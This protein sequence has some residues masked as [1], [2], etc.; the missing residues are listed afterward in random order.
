MRRFRRGAL[1][2]SLLAALSGCASGHASAAHPSPTPA[3]YH[4]VEPTPPP[5]RPE[6]VLTDLNGKAFDFQAETKGRPTFVYFGYTHCPDACPTA[7]ADL[8][9]ALRKV[10]P[11]LRSLVKIIFVTTDPQRDTAP[12]M[13]QWLGQFDAPIIGLTGTPAQLALAQ[14]AS[15]V[16]PAAPDGV[17]PT[18]AGHPD[19]H[20]HQPGTAPHKHFGPLGYAVSHSAVIF[21]YDAADRLPVVYPGGVTPSDIAADIPLLAHP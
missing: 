8:A 4:G 7:M 10:S 19:E 17:T 18:I 12:V 16:A 20:V 14:Q 9:V 1:A 11:Q 13:R 21:A 3:S 2:L 5:P 15:G 6:F